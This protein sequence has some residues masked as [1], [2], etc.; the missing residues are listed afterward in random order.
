M[1]LT[2]RE[3]RILFGDDAKCADWCGL[4]YGDVKTPDRE[5]EQSYQAPGESS[6]FERAAYCT[7]ACL[8]RAKANHPAVPESSPKREPVAPWKACDWFLCSQRPLG[9]DNCDYSVPACCRLGAYWMSNGGPGGAACEDCAERAGV[10][11][12]VF[13]EPTFADLKPTGKHTVVATFKN[14]E[15][16]VSASENVPRDAERRTSKTPR[17]VGAEIGVQTAAGSLLPATCVGPLA[18]HGAPVLRVVGSPY[19][20]KGLLLCDGCYLNHE[21]TVTT[22]MDEDDTPEY[23]A[24]AGRPPKPSAIPPARIGTVPQVFGLNVGIWASRGLRGR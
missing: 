2:E 3:W 6:H 14:Y 13:I 1:A 11:G 10:F 9:R 17:D 21:R 5:C 19:T 15:P 16:V 24:A 18:T 7:A 23:M 4:L 8:E 12:P 20:A 22:C